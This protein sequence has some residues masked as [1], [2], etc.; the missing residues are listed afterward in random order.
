MIHTSS[1][2]DEWISY[3]PVNLVDA[4]SIPADTNEE[5][6]EFISGDKN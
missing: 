3:W 5:S 4:R 2:L 6:Q 1:Q